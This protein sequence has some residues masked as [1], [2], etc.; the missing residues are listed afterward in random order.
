MPSKVKIGPEELT[1]ILVSDAPLI[2]SELPFAM[3][4][5]RQRRCAIGIIGDRPALVL[6][7]ASRRNEE[8]A[9]AVSLA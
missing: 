5:T 4:A 8:P 1:L 7:H 3:S 6:P 9:R 2:G